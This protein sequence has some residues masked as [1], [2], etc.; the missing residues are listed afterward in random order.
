MVNLKKTSMSIKNILLL[1]TVFCCAIPVFS[2]TK[3]SAEASSRCTQSLSLAE[4]QYKAGI[5]Q[6]IPERLNSCLRG[7]NFSKEETIRAYKLLTLV[8]IFD[9][10]EKLADDNM[11]QLLKAD[12]E[13][14]YDIIADPA[15]FIFLYNKYRTKPIF[16]VGVT[17]SNSITSTNVIRSFT[18]N[19]VSK[20]TKSYSTGTGI[21]V[22]VSIEKEFFDYFEAVFSVGY[23]NKQ[24][25]YIQSDFG[26]ETDPSPNDNPSRG[27]SVLESQNW[28]DANA[29]V[30]AYYPVGNFIP[31][32]YLGG[33]VNY[34]QSASEN[35][36][37][38]AVS[39]SNIDLV[40]TQNREQLNFSLVY[41]AGLK[42]RQKVNFVNLEVK[43]MNGL[44]NVVQGDNRYP[45]IESFDANVVNSIEDQKQDRLY[46][47]G[48]VDDNF[49]VNTLFFSIGY[50]K[51]FYNPKKLN[52]YR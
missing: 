46:S 18:S 13:H 3:K 48:I 42:I 22:A 51:S 9:D 1:I 16:R 27:F 26:F 29:G 31:Y 50:I 21:G 15:E 32:V 35:G 33:A 14:A 39:T 20:E 41:G 8:Y 52:G 44:T 7:S 11:V 23:F 24:F 34:L 30:R 37:R 25:S 36:T 49:S 28:L 19:P 47:V 40:K 10:N 2:Q 12:P 43:Y 6:G 38:G 4:D 5:L 45:V 17:A